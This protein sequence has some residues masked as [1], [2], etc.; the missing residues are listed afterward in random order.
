MPE[1][2]SCFS[3]ICGQVNEAVKCCEVKFTKICLIFL[4]EKTRD[5]VK[6]LNGCVSVLKDIVSYLRKSASLE[7]LEVS[8]QKMPECNQRTIQLLTLETSMG[9]PKWHGSSWQRGIAESGS[10]RLSTLMIDVPRDLVW[11]LPCVQ[12]ASYLGGPLMWMLPLYLHVNQKSDYIY[13]YNGRRMQA[14]VY[15][16]LWTW[17]KSALSQWN[18]IY[19]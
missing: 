16:D 11:D 1:N 3:G 14:S 8:I 10:S 15:H 12:Q 9:A 4:N 18:S 5:R 19:L 13:I 7:T 17:L 2:C 6:R